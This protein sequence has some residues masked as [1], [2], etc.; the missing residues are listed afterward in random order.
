MPLTAVK[1]M[2][3]WRVRNIHERRVAVSAWHRFIRAVEGARHTHPEVLQPT[4]EHQMWECTRDDGRH[5][6]PTILF[7]HTG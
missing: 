3:F 7:G 2:I 1:R 4:P 5:L 6:I